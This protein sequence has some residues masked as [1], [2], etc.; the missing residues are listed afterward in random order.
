MRCEWCGT[1]FCCDYAD[2][3]LGAVRKRHCSEQCR[4]L[5]EQ[6]RYR[7]RKNRDRCQSGTIPRFDSKRDAWREAERLTAET[8]G[9]TGRMTFPAPSAGAGMSSARRSTGPGRESATGNN[10]ASWMATASPHAC[11]LLAVL[12]RA[13]SHRRPPA[14]QQSHLPDIAYFSGLLPG[15][16]VT[17]GWCFRKWRRSQ[18][19]PGCRATGLTH[20]AF[21]SESVSAAPFSVRPHPG[22][23]HG[24]SS[25]VLRLA[26]SRDYGSLS[27]HE[28]AQR[29]LRARARTPAPPARLRPRSLQS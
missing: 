10:P 13:L 18:C 25:S 12:N 15:M 23:A 24:E 21:V 1:V 28:Q 8:G 20:R 6:Y 14:C 5:H 22:C 9:G 26:S 4:A 2:E 17:S 27:G 3:A 19:A 29:R 11:C 16:S 7:M